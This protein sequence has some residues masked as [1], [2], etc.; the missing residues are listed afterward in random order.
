VKELSQEYKARLFEI[1]NDSPF[2]TH[3]RMRMTELEYASSTFVMSAEGFRMQPY[4]VMHGGNMAVLID[5]A[6]FW[7]CFLAMCEDGD[8]LTSVDLKVNYLAPAR[9]ESLVCKARLIKSGKTLAYADAEVRAGD[10]RRLV[11]HGS[12]TLMRIPGGGLRLGLPMFRE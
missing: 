2:S 11:A 6:T 5:S 7:A 10:D 1:L 3:V 8:A 9:H 4:Q 12:S